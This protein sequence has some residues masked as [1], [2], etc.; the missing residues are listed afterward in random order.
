[1]G[2]YDRDWHKAE[3]HQ[4][5]IADRARDANLA[6]AYGFKVGGSSGPWSSIGRVFALTLLLC[7]AIYG[8]LSL[9]KNFPF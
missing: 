6:K 3:R 8:A 7:L 5:R 4:Q 1:M 9:I 2:I